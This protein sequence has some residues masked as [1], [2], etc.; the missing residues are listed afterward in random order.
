MRC[1]VW[2]TARKL[3]CRPSSEMHAPSQRP[4]S[5]LPRLA[6]CVAN[7]PAAFVDHPNAVLRV[8]RG[9]HKV[10]DPEQEVEKSPSGGLHGRSKCQAGHPGQQLMQILIR[11]MKSPRA[12]LPFVYRNYAAIGDQAISSTALPADAS[13]W[14]FLSRPPGDEM[15][16]SG[17][18][19]TISLS[20]RET[21]R[22]SA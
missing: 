14:L 16:L 9:P 13:L 20:V 21:S 17:V 2:P 10:A 7:K 5:Q 3:S 6:R 8:G 11:S 15:A 18:V 4:R 19:Y 1:V 12:A 22:R